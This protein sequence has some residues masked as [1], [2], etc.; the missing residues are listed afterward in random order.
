MARSAAPGVKMRPGMALSS[1]TP[2]PPCAAN[3]VRAAGVDSARLAPSVIPRRAGGGPRRGV[4]DGHPGD[5]RPEGAPARRR[6]RQRRAEGRLRRLVRD[7]RSAAIGGAQAVGPWI[8]EAAKT[9]DLTKKISVR[10]RSSG[11][12]RATRSKVAGTKRTFSFNDLPDGPHDRRLPDREQRP[13]RRV[14][15][16]PEPIAAQSVSWSAAA[17][18]D[19]RRRKPSCMPTGPDRRAR[20]RRVPL[21]RAR[22]RGPRRG[23][24]RGARR[25]RRPS[26]PVEQLPPP[27]HPA[28]PALAARRRA[29]DAR[30]LRARRLRDLPRQGRGRQRCPRTPR[31]TRATGRRASSAGTASRRASTTTSRRSSTR[32]RSAAST[33][34]RSRPAARSAAGR[35]RRAVPSRRGRGG[36]R[37]PVRAIGRPEV[38]PE[39][40]EQP[41]LDPAR[42]PAE[43]EGPGGEDTWLPRAARSRSSGP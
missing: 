26:R 1:I 35:L 29:A 10:A 12:R 33:A 13:G 40:L 43:G 28:V 25:L 21:Q 30:R 37:P 3:T 5:D 24:A 6:P 42:R 14:R 4:R 7:A 15:P 23:R 36:Q 31:S 2:V 8:D 27:R 38:I 22:R 16:Q 18:P 17:E 20:R 41:A 9:W 39:V 19:R 34:R 11:R 32:T